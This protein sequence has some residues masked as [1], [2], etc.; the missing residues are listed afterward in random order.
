MS[1][2]RLALV[3]VGVTAAV[4][5]VAVLV[6]GSLVDLTVY[7][8]GGSSLIHGIP[9]YTTEFPADLPFTYP[10]FAAVVFSW[11]A[12]LPWPAAV[13]VLTAIG[14]AA[15]AAS[16][17]LVAPGR[18]VPLAVAAVGVGLAVEPVR[19]TLLFG[20][21][22][23]VLMGLVAADCLLP[24]V[25][26][27]RGMLIG[28]AA[29]AKLTPAFFVL[30]FLTRR[31]F[32]PVATAATTFAGAA[33]VAT[34]VTP[35][36]S[37][38]YWTATVFDTDRIG[39]AGFATNQSLRGMLHRLGLNPFSET[40]AWS[41]LVCSVL[42]L[43]WHAARR[44]HDAAEPVLALLVVAAAGL[45]VSPVSWSHHW[46]WI[47]PALAFAAVRFRGWLWVLP[48][49]VAGQRWLP[50]ADDRELAWSG[51]QHLVGNGY[52]LVAV[53]F[54]GWAAMRECRE[55]H[56]HDIPAPATLR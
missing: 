20:Q 9:L 17:A 7:R 27:P 5:L 53:V 12:V 36:D 46:V 29:A 42:L 45:L 43:A 26:Y 44:A 18:A 10:P 3:G 25:R 4:V 1:A 48:V 13:A 50:H 49:F 40:M 41:L 51:W 47:V 8:A 34:M 56:L 21:I 55:G 15:L 23:L 14:L 33:V 31:Q 22:N 37:V 11:L 24:K 6:P 30:F 52:L 2:Q 19:D 54:L 35:D 16:V 32:T 38:T 39:G 28:L